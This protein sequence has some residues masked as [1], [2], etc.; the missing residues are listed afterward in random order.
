MNRLI[1]IALLSSLV[2]VGCGHDKTASKDPVPPSDLT[3]SAQPLPVP[4][5]PVYPAA[6]ETAVAMTPA[7]TPAPAPTVKSTPAA[8]PAVA[9][10]KPAAASSKTYVVKK[11]D[12]LSEI[13]KMHN[14]TVKKIMAINPAIKTADKI[15]IG[16]KIKLP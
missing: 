14:T 9:A 4:A 2:A 16:Q 12:S 8:K 3:P 6:P 13:A 11:G 1:P 10:V 5:T 15:E 7:P